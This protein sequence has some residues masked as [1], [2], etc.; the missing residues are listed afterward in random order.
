MRILF[1]QPGYH[2]NQ[3]P[4][5]KGLTDNGHDVKYI[6]QRKNP[7]ENND[8][9]TPNN[10]KYSITIKKVLSFLD[11]WDSD[12]RKKVGYP[13][14]Y[15]LWRE[16]STFQPDIVIVRDYTLP[17]ALAL[18][19]GNKV[20]AAGIVQQLTPKYGDQ[21][22]EIK[23]K[24]GRLYE[25]I[26]DQPLVRV[27][28]IKGQ[29]Q[30]NQTSKNTYFIPHPVDIDLYHEFSGKKFFIHDRINLITVGRFD[31]D[32]KKIFE[33]VK[34][35]EALSCDY[36]IH[37]TLVGTLDDPHN[38]SYRRIIDFIEQN[39]LKSNIDICLNV[40]NKLLQKK[41]SDHDIFV[42]PAVNEPLG[43]AGL[44]AM[45]AGLPVICADDSGVSTYVEEGYNGYTIDP[46]SEISLY[47]SIRK[48]ISE[49]N[50]IKAMGGNSRDQ[51]LE[52]HL[53]KHYARKFE[54]IVQ[55]RFN[56]GSN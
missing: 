24:I 30:D 55:N 53:P 56:L 15:K 48:I 29:E 47:N 51:I 39:G 2:P 4:I 25:S 18:L 20:G 50:E 34:V 22:I 36:P 28:P 7:A 40:D 27:T 6:V 35:F 14:I 41:Y 23:K 1:F 3:H 5:V 16:V 32:R 46:G 42:F 31:S 52:N 9:L 19:F 54:F 26:F 44:E 33:L 49:K 10:I 37:L 38:A 17:S 45:A 43:M 11:K 21:N 8:I 12:S 13:P